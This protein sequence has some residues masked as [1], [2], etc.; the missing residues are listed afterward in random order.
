MFTSLKLGS[1]LLKNRMVM[2]PMTRLR[3][4]GG[5]ANSLMAEYYRQRASAGLLVTECTAVHPTSGA[6]MG[7]PGIFSDAQA[8]AWA[9]VAAAVHAEGGLIFL[10]LWHS[11]RIA[12]PSLIPDGQLP[13][14]PSAV[15]GEAELHTPSGKEPV[16][17]PA[18]MDTGQIRDITAAFGSAARRAR[19]AGFDGVEVHGA[20]GYLIEQFLTDGANRRSDAYGGSMQARLCFLL[21]VL[22]AVQ[23]VFPRDTGLKLS[24]SNTAHGI[25]ESDRAGLLEALLESLRGRGLAYLHLMRALEADEGAP[26]L[27]DDPLR[28][29]REGW[30]GVLI[31]NGR[32]D[33]AEAQAAIAAKRCDAVSFG[34]PFIANPDLPDRL[35]T[36]GELREPDFSTVYAVPG[37]DPERGYTDY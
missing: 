31:A 19:D 25:T 24:P 3:A 26:G 12:H 14:A 34:R 17:Q 11:G 35:G 32:F 33:G 6:Y 4:E 27:I 20:F 8:E 37:A 13:L 9:Q 1:H 18:A 29:A 36:G 15:A 5:M 28:A 30:D 23:A 22:D 2:A 7:A 16:P 10:Q 21:E